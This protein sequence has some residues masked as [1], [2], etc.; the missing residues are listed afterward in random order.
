MDR[1]SDPTRAEEGRKEQILT[2]V[3]EVASKEGFD[4]VT[5]RKVA[6][7]AGVSHGLVTYHY[8]TRERLILEA[9]RSLLEHES[10]RRDETVGRAGALKR[11]EEGYR[12]ALTAPERE[13]SPNLRLDFLVKT[14][15]TPRL[16]EAYVK[17]STRDRPRRIAGLKAEAASGRLDDS[18]DVELVEDL[19]EVVRDGLNLWT[20]LNLDES[21][22][23]RAFEIAQ[24]F[25]SLIGPRKGAASSG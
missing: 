20:A 14:A 10:R 21:A 15:R 7:L 22:D 17:D 4:R 23:L 18:L 16:L 11:I 3:L 6:A 25:L 24:F 12:L 1:A 8:G 19:I 9:W 13:V 5:V 2:A